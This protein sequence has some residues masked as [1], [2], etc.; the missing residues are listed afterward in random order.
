M[1]I[2]LHWTAGNYNIEIPWASHLCDFISRQVIWDSFY[3]FF[4]LN[5]LTNNQKHI[6]LYLN[7]SFLKSLKGGTG[8]EKA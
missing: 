2:Y 6:K 5:A 3:T 7:K 4:I 1:I 8:N